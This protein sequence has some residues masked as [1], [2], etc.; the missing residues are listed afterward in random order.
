MG[1]TE[2][3]AVLTKVPER[4]RFSVG[5]LLPVTVMA[6]PPSPAGKLTR[7]DSGKASVRRPPSVPSDVSNA[8]APALEGHFDVWTL[9]PSN[10]APAGVGDL[11][12]RV[13]HPDAARKCHHLLL[14]LG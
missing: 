5:A 12:I 9:Y 13:M 3:P 8:G 11:V 14:R 6:K 7:S 4:E 2:G 10:Q 1:D